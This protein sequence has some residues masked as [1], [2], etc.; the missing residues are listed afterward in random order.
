MIPACYSLNDV[1]RDYRR[2]LITEKEVIAYIKK[3][4]AQPCRL[5]QAV[6][7]D[8]SI[9]NFDPEVSGGFYRHLKEKFGLKL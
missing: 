1:E 6:L 7:S 5:T 2:G 8:G 9:R 3:W 4:N